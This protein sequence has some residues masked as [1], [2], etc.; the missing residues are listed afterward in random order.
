MNYELCKLIHNRN[1]QLRALQVMEN[2]E[3]FVMW[4]GQLPSPLEQPS[5]SLEVE[6]RNPD[7]DQNREEL[8]TRETIR[9]GIGLF[10]EF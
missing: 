5:F 3:V 1:N 10:I 9:I 2:G 7:A 4:N 6:L 8:V